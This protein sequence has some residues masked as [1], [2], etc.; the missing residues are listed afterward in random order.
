MDNSVCVRR[1]QNIVKDKNCIRL[2]IQLNGVK[3]KAVLDTGS[4]VSIISAKHTQ[5]INPVIY[6]EIS[7]TAK[8]TD[9]NGNAVKLTGEFETNTKYGDKTLTV[10]KVVEGTKEPI[11]GMDNIPKLGIQIFTG[12]ESLEINWFCENNEGLVE[13]LTNQFSNLFEENHTV[14]GLEVKI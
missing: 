1:I 13:Q 7:S 6:R 10:W 4:H 11:I 2:N 9:F 8:Y 5:R 3:V 12:G 14:H